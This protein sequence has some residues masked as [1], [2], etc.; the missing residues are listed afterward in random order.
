MKK[1]RFLLVALVATLA[2]GCGDDGGLVLPPNTPPAVIP[3]GPSEFPL[4]STDPAF[5]TESMTEDVTIILNTA[6]TAADGFS[7]ELYA[8]TGVLTSESTTTGDWK[9]VKSEWGENIPECKL[10]SQGDNIW[11]YVIKG[12]PR[13]FYGVP[14]GE[15][16]THLAFVFRSADSMIEVKD[17][18]ADIFVELATE[19]MSVKFLTPKNGQILTVGEECS[20]QVQQQEATKV[21]LYKN[22]EV[23]AESGSALIT[24]D[25][26]PEE[27]ADVVFKAVATDG[28]DTIEERVSVAILAATQ[29]AERPAGV[30]DG[31]NIDGTSATFVLYAPGKSSVVL[32]GDFNNYTPSNEYLMK[33]DG[34]YF[35]ATV[36]NLEMG[37][38]YGYQ[39]LVDGVVK[40]GDPYAE[41][42]LD[43]WNDKWID[44]SVY[45]D[46]KPYPSQYTSDIVSVFQLDK[47]EYAWTVTDFDRPK[48]NSLAIYE[49]LIRDFSDEGSI[50]AVTAKLDYLETLGVN[51]IE[52]MPIQE[53]D[54]NDSWGYNPCFYFAADKAYGTEEAYKR[55]IDECHKRGIAVILD[56]VFNHATGQFP[57]AKMWWDSGANKTSSDNPFFN[58]DAPHNWSVFHDFKHLYPKT[59]EYFKDVLKY[60]LEE[61]KV[62]GFR[63]DLTKGFV[64]K[65]G[66]YD[67][68]GYSSERITILSD[69]AMAIREVEQ[70]AYIIFEHFCD[71]REEE[72]LYT[73]VGALC[74]SNNAMGGYGE[75]V[76]GW[77]D[78]GKVDGFWGLMGDFKSNNWTTDIA[79]VEQDGFLVA[80][81]VVFAD[82][83]K[84]GCVFKVRKNRNWE[85]SYGVADDKKLYEL[86][87][88]ISLNGGKNVLVNAEVGV[89]YDFYFQP[90]TMKIYVMPDGAKPSAA[91]LRS[92]VTRAGSQSNFSDIKRGRV[93]NIETHDE[94]RIAYKAVTNGQ[95]YVKDDWAVL[96]KRL[97]AIY[98]FHFLSPY[99]KM[100]WQ[101]GELGYDYSIDYN[102]RTGRKPVRWDYYDDANRRALYDAMSKIISWRTA[103][104]D[105]YGGDNFK[106]DTWAVNDVNM[107]GK[108]LVMDRVIVVANFTEEESTTTVEVS[109]PGQWKNL[110]SGESVTLGSTYDVTLGGSDYIVLVR[111]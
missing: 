38:E 62:D 50:D 95:T 51:A 85:T 20:V 23:V 96:S 111:D 16:I 41:K 49:L 64:Q 77:Y 5:V 36:S 59:R 9:Y 108:T 61:Y 97:Q 74:W 69:Y 75:T 87:A 19:G 90:E 66:D 107:D 39:F 104:E 106:M 26:V 98:A 83:N 21:T 109:T 73:K 48:E 27:P 92:A 72:E 44:A 24:Y 93:N 2:L 84:E 53:F 63:F 68:G 103:N 81:D 89:K 56:V 54:G 76:M 101:F 88:V 30:V 78:D 99:P 102:D 105:Y 80:E 37:T 12:G 46:L 4:I 40:V 58:V 45:P 86:G 15:T 60:W 7:G 70:D 11:H 110:L 79:F 6:G 35:W 47:P 52:L 3:G 1:L 8:H 65:P 18:G 25:F 22:D 43:P 82:A 32:L 42:I 55:F 57:W 13:A 14:E 100:M 34:D 17:N 10:K 31:V 67:A 94:E 71:Q 91:A 33:R 29:E 28:I